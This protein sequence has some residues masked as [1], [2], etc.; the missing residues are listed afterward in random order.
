MQNEIFFW[1]EKNWQF[2]L[3][4][5]NNDK[6]THGLLLKGLPGLG[7][8]QFAASLCQYIL[9]D[10]LDKSS[11][12]SACNHCHSCHLFQEG[13]HPD[14]IEI[15]PAENKQTITTAQIK[16]QLEKMNLSS[17]NKGAKICVIK[18]AEA[19]NQFAANALLKTL[20]EPVSAKTLFI[21]VTDAIEFLLP[22][23]R[24]R[25]QHLSFTAPPKN[26]TLCWLE[27]QNCVQDQT[28]LE[29][30]LTLANQSP[31]LTLEILEDKAAGILIEFY[32]YL[33]TLWHE[34]TKNFNENA[35]KIFQALD[36][37]QILQVMQ[38][39]ILN[40]IKNRTFESVQ[41]LKLYELQKDLIQSKST[42]KKNISLNTALVLEAYLIKIQNIAV[43]RG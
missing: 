32:Q 2:M 36:L 43:L 9:C 30:A 1:Q 12:K 42:V 10:T 19:M 26:K 29:L 40:L 23:I 22:T 7:K 35:L 16:T 27:T 14:H 5:I 17:Y 3:D 41:K 31:L 38:I 28:S 18:P 20:E 21:L 15:F 34:K 37:K 24:S 4:A 39:F 8:A 25:V 6:L 11:R 33:E 13:N